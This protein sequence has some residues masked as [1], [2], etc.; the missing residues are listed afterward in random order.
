MITP[1]DIA[2][3]ARNLAGQLADETRVRCAIGRSY[4]AAFHYCRC[5]AGNWCDPLPPNEKQGRGEHEK[6]YARLQGHSKI[7]GL[8]AGL[9]TIAEQAKKLR[10]LRVDADY[11][12]NKTMNTKDLTR[13]LAYLS[14]IEK[15]FAS[16]SKISISL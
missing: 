16:L 6:L 3:L 4:Y 15:E 11:H 5:A 2:K 7:S 8:D 1:E 10:N 9:R 14:Q 12:L 13:S